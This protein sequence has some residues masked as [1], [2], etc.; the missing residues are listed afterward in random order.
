MFSI[1]SPRVFRSIDPFGVFNC[2]PSNHIE[3]RVPGVRVVFS[4]E[5]PITSHHIR[6]R[7]PVTCTHSHGRGGHRSCRCTSWPSHRIRSHV[8]AFR[9]RERAADTYIYR[10]IYKYVEITHTRITPHTQIATWIR[11]RAVS[12]SARASSDRTY[13]HRLM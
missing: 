5:S 2:V 1:E 12:S 7:P 9:K 8:G 10:G 11:S 6:P 3:S 4:I 13:H